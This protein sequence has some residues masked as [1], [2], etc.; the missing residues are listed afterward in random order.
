MRTVDLMESCS[1][2]PYAFIC[3]GGCAAHAM[4]LHGSYFREYCGE[5]REMFDFIA[6][7]VVGAYWNKTHREELSLTLKEP[8]SRLT[9]IQRKNIMDTG[10]KKEILDILKTAGIFDTLKEEEN[11][12]ARP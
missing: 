12:I 8:L 7:H 6:S 9:A 3:R 10:S 5:F 11:G 2:C 1:A 4:N